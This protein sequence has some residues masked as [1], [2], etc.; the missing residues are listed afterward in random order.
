M[1]HLLVLTI[2]AS[3]NATTTQ[4]MIITT[5]YF[6]NAT[7]SQVPSLSLLHVFLSKLREE[8]NLSFTKCVG[9]FS[10]LMSFAAISQ[11]QLFTFPF[12]HW[13]D[14]S[15]SQ[16][17][18]KM[19]KQRGLIDH[20]K[21]HDFDHWPYMWPKRWTSFNDKAVSQ[22]CNVLCWKSMRNMLRLFG[23]VFESLISSIIAKVWKLRHFHHQLVS[24]AGFSQRKK[25]L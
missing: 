22:S 18:F 20:G 21:N 23:Y 1:L 19:W 6:K 2:R 10:I 4:V 7:V 11:W 13:P 5:M 17:Q 14:N 25:H 3:E 8:E 16:C 24:C 12:G 9:K 15:L